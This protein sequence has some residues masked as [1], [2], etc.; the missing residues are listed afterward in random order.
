MV[1][2][3]LRNLCSIVSKQLCVTFSRVAREHILEWSGSSW[4]LNSTD[5][6]S[7]DDEIDMNPMA[8]AVLPPF[9]FMSFCKEFGIPNRK[10][11]CST[12]GS[13]IFFSFSSLQD[14]HL[15]HILEYKIPFLMVVCFP[16]KLN[17]S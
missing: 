12:R 9:F 17:C 3:S 15:I 8:I 16:L 5:G 10:D 2:L 6:S 14:H 4:Y 13:N 11:K 7:K 1:P